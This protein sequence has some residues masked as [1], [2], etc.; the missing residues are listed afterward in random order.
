M[1]YLPVQI[2][3]FMIEKQNSCKKYWVE[4]AIFLSLK[5][6]LLQTFDFPHSLV[7]YVFFENVLKYFS[8]FGLKY[9]GKYRVMEFIASSNRYFSMCLALTYTHTAVTLICVD[10]SER[11]EEMLEG[12]NVQTE[13]QFVDAKE[14]MNFQQFIFKSHY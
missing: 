5:G 2:F 14:Q 4:N 12:L 10:I 1:R 8:E 7:L 3:A 6:S 13:R 9:H 11:M